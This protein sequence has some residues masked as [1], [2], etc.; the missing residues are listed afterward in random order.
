L[1]SRIKDQ[2]FLNTSSYTLQCI[3]VKLTKRGCMA[4]YAYNDT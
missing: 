2:P 3:S 1:V 4:A